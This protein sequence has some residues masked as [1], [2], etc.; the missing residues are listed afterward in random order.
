MTLLSAASPSRAPPQ[1]QPGARTRFL[2]TPETNA[3]PSVFRELHKKICG[4]IFYAGLTVA[5]LPS[6]KP[7]QFCPAAP[8]PLRGTLPPRR[9]ASPP[10]RSPSPRAL[11]LRSIASSSAHQP[12][13]SI[14]RPAAF[15]KPP[16]ISLSSSA[17]SPF[18]HSS[19]ANTRQSHTPDR[20]NATPSPSSA[21]TSA[22][23]QAR[24]P[25]RSMPSESLPSPSRPLL[26]APAALRRP[27]KRTSLV[28]RLSSLP[29]LPNPHQPPGSP[30]HPPPACPAPFVPSAP[31]SLPR[32]LL[33]PRSPPKHPPSKTPEA[34]SCF[35][36][37]GILAMQPSP[38]CPGQ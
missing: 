5:A 37:E 15:P 16:H 33:G 27:H 21:R 6:S 3:P 31:A 30:L 35:L 9:H 12:A 2:S 18:C 23:I 1:K 25:S 13:L 22:Q 19:S 7:R 28:A 17:A 20:P 10:S 11:P 29:L 38:S 34:F 8:P 14:S 4:F 26:L 32:T 36:L 24:P